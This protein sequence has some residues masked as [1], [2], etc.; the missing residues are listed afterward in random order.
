[1]VFSGRTDKDATV[2]LKVYDSN[3]NLIHTL[4][5]AVDPETGRWSYT[6]PQTLP[7]GGY[8]FVTSVT[9]A[10]GNTN[11]SEGMKV[12]VD[13]TGPTLNEVS[14]DTEDNTGVKDDWSTETKQVTLVGSVSPDAQIKV[15]IPGLNIE[16][17][18]VVDPVTGKFTVELP[19]LPEGTHIIQV[20]AYDAAGNE[21]ISEESLR[22]GMDMVPLEV[23]LAE[24][25]D[26][27]VAGD[28]ITNDR[29][30]TFVGKGMPG[31]TVELSMPGH[32]TY[33][34]VVDAD[35]NWTL[36]VTKE[37]ES[38]N[39]SP[40]FVMKDSAGNVVKEVTFDFKLDYTNEITVEMDEEYI[41]GEFETENATNRD[42][43]LIKG[44]AEAGSQITITNKATGEVVSQSTTAGGTWSF[45]LT[46]LPEGEST[47]VIT[48]IDI[49][50]NTAEKEITIVSDHS[51]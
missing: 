27:G 45:M 51:C 26:T 12:T 24:S 47:F 4:T 20:I 21:T 9:D 6:M 40:T 22:I 15:K 13:R 5:P 28:N 46:N 7:D 16:V 19:E 41:T 14:I 35:G 25:S 18:G 31:Y 49:A 2:E 33:T 3:N 36:Q 37:L 10:A 30:P 43:A 29:T 17:A 38:L 48:S 44:T 23:G 42:S 11:D 1:M 39:Q 50:G 34:T 32:D 8:T